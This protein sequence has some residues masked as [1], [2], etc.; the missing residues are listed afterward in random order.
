MDAAISWGGPDF[1]FINT[2]SAA[3]G[4]RAKYA[5]QTMTVSIYGIPVLEEGMTYDLEATRIAELDPPE[6]TYVEDQTLQLDEE[7]VDDAGTMGSRWQ[8]RLV[9]KK[10]GEI[11]SQDV[12]HTTSYKGHAAVIKRNTSGVVIP[13]ESEAVEGQSGSVTDSSAAAPS[14][15]SAAMEE[16]PGAEVSPVVNETTPAESIAPET[17]PAETA[18]MQNEPA[19][20]IENGPSEDGSGQLMPG[21]VS[22][23]GSSQSTGAF[24][25]IVAP[26][27]EG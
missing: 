17:T 19:S 2:S 5:D 18:P 11:I 13:A 23:S 21:G 8:V 3:I 12:D 27:P 10:N 26:K 16:G 7:V 6:P 4:I 20:P 24:E 15:S 1:R 14:E 25:Q 9:V 22:P